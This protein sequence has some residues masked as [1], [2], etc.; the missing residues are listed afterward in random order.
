MK[1]IHKTQQHSINIQQTSVKST[2]RKTIFLGKIWRTQTIISNGQ[3]TK[4][5]GS[6][7]VAEIGRRKKKKVLYLLSP[8][9]KCRAFFIVL[10]FTERANSARAKRTKEKQ[11]VTGT[12]TKRTRGPRLR[13]KK[14]K[15]K[16]RRGSTKIV[17]VQ[18]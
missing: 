9:A 15:L 6:H 8:M 3:E 18:R 12:M 16:K 17:A 7:K 1:A 13:Y 2:V 11:K 14:K 10:F 5:A 4:R